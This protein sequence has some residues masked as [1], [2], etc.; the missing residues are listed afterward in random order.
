MLLA[1]CLMSAAV[2][3]YQ[4]P[5]GAP[6]AAAKPAT[7]P[8]IVRIAV[9]GASVSDGFGLEAEVGAR[10]TFSDVIE[11]SLKTEHKPVFG[12]TSAWLFM[13]PIGNAHQISVAAQTK[14]P[15][16]VVALD[17]LFWF[18]Y[19]EL[20]DEGAR[21]ALLE[22]GLRELEKFTCPVLIARFADVSAAVHGESLIGPMLSVKQVP[23][24]E[25]LNKLNERLLAWSSEHA[26]VILVPLDSLLASLQKGE[27]ISIH[28]NSWPKDSLKTLLQKDLLH[29]TL[30]GAIASWLFA[31][32]QMIAAQSEIPV[33]AFEWDAKEIDKKIRAA[34]EPERLAKEKV[35][36]ERERRRKE[37][38]AAAADPKSTTK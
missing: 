19:G 34:K 33:T 1:L 18:G 10:T 25:T 13:N 37:R 15:T 27:P 31:L 16:L 38:E 36:A 11:A 21:L 35:K 9:I 26:N 30:Q 4:T 22:K 12:Q 6:V 14:D 28:G 7:V 2:D 20:P 8:A 32:D 5:V 3:A 24:N 29:P 17:F 23:T